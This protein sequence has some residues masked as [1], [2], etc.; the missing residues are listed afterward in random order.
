MYA[1]WLGSVWRGEGYVLVWES[2]DKSE[3]YLQEGGRS[4]TGFKGHHVEF[5]QAIRRCKCLSRSRALECTNTRNRDKGRKNTFLLTV[6][7]IVGAG[8][9]IEVFAGDLVERTIVNRKTHWA[10]FFLHQNDWRRLG[11]TWRA[12]YIV[13]MHVPNSFANNL[14]FQSGHMVWAT[15]TMLLP[16]LSIQWVAAEVVISELACHSNDDLCLLNRSS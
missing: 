1:W 5:I 3:L 14:A 15:W 8:H 2:C 12:N 10:I 7:R 13:A 11:A 16:S 6:Q 4:I 9:W